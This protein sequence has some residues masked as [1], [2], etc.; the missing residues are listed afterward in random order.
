MYLTK[1][2]GTDAL[3]SISSCFTKKEEFNRSISCHVEINI[4][5][6]SIRLGYCVPPIMKGNMVNRIVFH[7]GES[8]SPHVLKDSF[9]LSFVIYFNYGKTLLGNILFKSDMKA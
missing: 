8:A 7:K 2:N 6:I 5:Y 1:H 4:V 9:F 3:L